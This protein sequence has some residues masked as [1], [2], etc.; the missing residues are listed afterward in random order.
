MPAQLILIPLPSSRSEQ[1]QPEGDEN[2]GSSAT[3]GSTAEPRDPAEISGGNPPKFP[4]WIP[5]PIGAVKV[6]GQ[7]ANHLGDFDSIS[8]MFNSL[9]EAGMSATLPGGSNTVF[10]TVKDLSGLEQTTV[11]QELDRLPSA[12]TIVVGPKPT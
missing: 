7:G 4:V 9:H 11:H 1:E 6:F 12:L 5:L 10:A 8:S 3:G 2:K